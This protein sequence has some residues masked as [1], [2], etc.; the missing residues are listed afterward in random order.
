[1]NHTRFAA[2]VASVFAACVV[3]AFATDSGDVRWSAEAFGLADTAR[4]NTLLNPDHSLLDAGRTVSGVALHGAGHWEAAPLSARF[5]GWIE[6][7]HTQNDDTVRGTLPEASL[8]WTPQDGHTL[9]GGLGSFRWGTAYLWNPSNPLAD[10][11]FNNASR[12]RSY[13][14]DGDRFVSYEALAGQTTYSIAAVE[15]TQRDPLLANP[16]QDERWLAARVQHIF[17]VSDAALHV[18]LREGERFLGVSA[19]RTVGNALELHGELGTRSQRR[20]PLWKN[21]TVGPPSA[22]QLPVWNTSGW[23]DWT[24]SAV[25]GGQYTWDGGVNLIVEY[26]HD[27]NGLNDRE[28]NA[29]RAA[30]KDAGN[31]RASPGFAEVANG[32]L[33]QANGYTGRLRRNYAF[34]RLAKD[35]LVANTDAQAFARRGLDDDSWILGWM[36]RWQAGEHSALALSGEHLRGPGGSEAALVP[37]RDRYQLSFKYDF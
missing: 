20:M 37:V 15:L 2:W 26:L 19:S 8:H 13:Y 16:P 25:F 3:P 23:K 22:P 10:N 7:R 30:A 12:A 1:M 24:T 29:L 35:G 14:R 32:F 34:V 28:Y 17:E 9:S 5:D 33:L 18:A 27:G 21:L 36:L 4:T 31:L 6:A 11:E